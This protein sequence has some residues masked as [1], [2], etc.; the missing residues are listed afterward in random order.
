MMYEKI[1]MTVFMFSH[2]KG[3]KG[4]TQVLLTIA[5]SVIGRK[6]KECVLELEHGVFH[7]KE[8][9]GE[10][11]SYYEVYYNKDYSPEYFDQFDLCKSDVVIFDI[12]ANIGITSTYYSDIFPNGVIHSFEP[13]PDTLMRCE[14]NTRNHSNIT[15]NK[16]AL[17]K[18][19][20]SV[21]FEDNGGTSSHISD[22]GIRVQTNTLDQYVK[23]CRIKH[24]DLMK[25][26]VEGA[27]EMVLEGGI[28]SLPI[29]D[30]IILEVHSR[31]LYKA[32]RLILESNKF[33]LVFKR[34]MKNTCMVYWSKAVNK[35]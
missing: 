28:D 29:V 26:D 14:K 34:E 4:K 21:L 17:S 2:S 1:K 3:I 12:G 22:K 33:E 19:V 31:D 35:A 11:S 32:V 6:G 18:S 30:N 24:I 25:I 8:G 16:V 10:L 15:L 5:R 13:N 23:D 9:L 20:G 7:Y 27:E